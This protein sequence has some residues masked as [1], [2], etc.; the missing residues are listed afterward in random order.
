MKSVMNHSFSNVPSVDIPRSVFD[1][2]HGY[3]TAMEAG[4]LVPFYCDEALPGDTFKAR[5]SL[6]AR[7]ATPTVPIM[8]N[9]FLETFFFAVPN[10]LLWDNWE[11]FNGAQTDPGDSTDYLVPKITAPVGGFAEG[12]LADFFGIPTKKANIAVNALHFRA[13]NL[14][15]NEWFRDQNLDNSLQV[16]KTDGPDLDTLYNVN[17][18]NKQHDYFTSALPWPQK[19]DSVTL[20]LGGTAPVY[21]DGNAL[22]IEDDIGNKHGLFRREN[23]ANDKFLDTDIDAY[24]EP[25]GEPTGT[26]VGFGVAKGLGVSTVSGEAGLIADLSTATV[27][28]IN[29]LREAFQIQKMLE[30][31]ARGG[32]RYTEII[33]THFGV[34]SPDSRLQRPEYLGGSSSRVNITPVPQISSTTGALAQGSLSGYGTAHSDSAGFNKSF[35]EHCVLIGLVNIRADLNYQQGLNRMWSRQTR[36]DYYWPSFAHLGE[37]AIINQEIYYNDDANDLDVFGYQER[38]AE[39][40]YKPSLVTGLFRTNATASL[41]VWHLAENFGSRPALNTTFMKSNPPM[42]RVQAVT[43]E[44]AF[45]FDSY[46]KLQCARPM[47]TY[48]V[49]GLIDHF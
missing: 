44:P 28:T 18:R 40:R 39:Y 25:I 13:Y 24:N 46:M 26:H 29:A 37:Q 45:I 30:K 35:T 1:R 27:A 49:P 16:P 11:K 31:D 19:G 4:F 6:F 36:Y 10:R 34:I 23:A 21:G 22:G 7:M 48:S 9:L 5:T 17:F 42:D 47:P 43:S 32:T 20:P 8:D 33:R 12:S 3:K 41:D 38:Y 15:Y 2:T 14:I